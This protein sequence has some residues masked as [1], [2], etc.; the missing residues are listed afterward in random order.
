MALRDEES[1]FNKQQLLRKIF[2]LYF[3]IHN[4]TKISNPS[5][6]HNHPMHRTRSFHNSLLLLQN[7]FLLNKSL[8]PITWSIQT[9]TVRIQCCIYSYLGSIQFVLRYF[10]VSCKL[11]IIYTYKCMYERFLQVSYTSRISYEVSSLHLNTSCG[12][13]L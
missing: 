2:H 4:F 9:Y 11:H 13:E 3:E 10:T 7:H 5:Q 8:H 12:R 6:K 1:C